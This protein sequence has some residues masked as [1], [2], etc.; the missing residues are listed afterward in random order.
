M[1][2]Y[3]LI[4]IAL[5]TLFGS[6]AYGELPD[7][8]DGASTLWIVNQPEEVVGYFLFDPSTVNERLPSKLRFITV[9][10]LASGGVMWA[11]DHLAENPMHNRWGISFFEIVRMGT[12]KIDGY[13]PSW[14]PNGAMALWAARVA[15][16]DSSDNLGLAR[17]L[18]VLE[19]WLPDSQYVT[20]MREKG[21]YATYGS[22]ELRQKNA[23]DTWLG[24][25]DVEG[26]IV[27]V[28]CTPEGPVTGGAGSR[29]SQ[30][31]F[32]PKSSGIIYDVTVTFAGHQIQECEEEASWKL[33]GTHALAR[34]TPLG[35]STFQF[36]YELLGGAFK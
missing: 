32:P 6:Y 2:K 13:A 24:Y 22:V 10:E 31:L 5:V 26:L 33:E 18:L 11:K 12:F 7:L 23:L 4:T 27:S 16:S 1:R 9:G 17:P 29:G 36:G 21:H 20:Y 35:P 14:P 34:S 8:P 25:V 28:Q 15:P 30:T 19:F 3:I